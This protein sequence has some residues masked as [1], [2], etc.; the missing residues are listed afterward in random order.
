[1]IIS[2]R[3]QGVSPSKLPGQCRHAHE[4]LVPAQ[5][6]RKDVQKTK[7]LALFAKT[8]F[9]LEEQSQPKPNVESLEITPKRWEQQVGLVKLKLIIIAAC[10]SIVT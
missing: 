2:D 6:I 8:A 7:V 3:V 9:T 10:H 1:M 4:P 5:V